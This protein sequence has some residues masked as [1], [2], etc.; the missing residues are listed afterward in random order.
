MPLWDFT[1]TAGGLSVS[2]RER[3]TK[4]I[5]KMY[6][7]VGM[8]AFY[9]Q[10]RF[11]ETPANSIYIAGKDYSSVKAGQSKYACIQIYHVARSLI[12]DLAKRQF[13]NAVDR[14]LGR[15][16]NDQDWEWEYWVTETP[17]DTWK[18]NCLIP[19]PTGSET[20]KKWFD[21]NHPIKGLVIGKL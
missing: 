7:S 15:V 5:T 20:E 18:I 2:D 10:V 16:F 1:F 11:T 12:S 21:A 3:L 13:L 14:V 19:P 9:V 4:S 6:T 17:R 8:P